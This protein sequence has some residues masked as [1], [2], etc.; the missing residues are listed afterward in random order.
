MLMYF[1]RFPLPL[2]FPDVLYCCILSMYIFV[3]SSWRKAKGDHHAKSIRRFQLVLPIRHVFS[4]LGRRDHQAA[5]MTRLHIDNR[6]KQIWSVMIT[7]AFPLKQLSSQFWPIG[8]SR[9]DRSSIRA[10]DTYRT[11][12]SLQR[13]AQMAMPGVSEQCMPTIVFDWK[14][15]LA[16]R[17]S[18]S[19]LTIAFDWE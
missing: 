5:N 4:H 1:L 17:N 18:I 3:F 16:F 10:P 7:A 13:R 19:M 8:A 15:R 6:W 11:R 9:D 2:L 14:S 12:R